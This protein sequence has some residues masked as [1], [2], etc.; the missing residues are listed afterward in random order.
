MWLVNSL[1]KLQIQTNNLCIKY[2]KLQGE[3]KK[4]K[5]KKDCIMQSNHFWTEFGYQ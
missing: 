2:L 4:E 3:K 5:K 1:S